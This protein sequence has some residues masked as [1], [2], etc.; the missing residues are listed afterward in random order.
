LDGQIASFSSNTQYE[1]PGNIGVNV[2]IVPMGP[3]GDAV[4]V[5]QMFAVTL[6][7]LTNM[8]VA[9][10]RG[11]GIKPVPEPATMI[12]MGTGAAAALMRRRR[13][14]HSTQA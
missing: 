8:Q 11:I 6:P 14:R 5:F 12:L 7:N 9:S 10:S 4:A 3:Q 2:D 1:L 13:Q